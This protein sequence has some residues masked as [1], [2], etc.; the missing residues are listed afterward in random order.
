MNYVV[1]VCNA[2][3]N[4]ACT[5]SFPVGWAALMSFPE[6]FFASPACTQFTLVQSDILSL[7]FR[8][9]LNMNH[10]LATTFKML[11]EFPLLCFLELKCFMFFPGCPPTS[12]LF[13]F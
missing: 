12:I 5:D 1:F 13:S 8:Q 6:V 11:P 4:H 7:G 10:L 3:R 2:N 9:E